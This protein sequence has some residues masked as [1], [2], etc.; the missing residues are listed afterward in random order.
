MGLKGIGWEG[1]DRMHVVQDTDHCCEHGNE[2]SGSIK[3]GNLLNSWVTVSF[4]IRTL[5]HGVSQK[6]KVKLSLCFFKLATRY[7]GVLGSGDIAPHI[8]DLGTKWRWVVS[9]TPP[10]LYPQGKG[11][12]THWI[13]GW[14]GSRA[15]L[16]AVVKRKIPSQY[17]GSNDRSSRP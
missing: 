13:G 15:V 8:L 10:P 1:V 9:F 11:P 3:A 4:S 2:S 6:V 12:G 7:E 16:N 17:R 5:V 14:V